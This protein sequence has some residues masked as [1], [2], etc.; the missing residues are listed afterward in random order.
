MFPG[1]SKKNA[2]DAFDYQGERSA[3]AIV[4]A[5]LRE[6]DQSGVPKEATEMTSVQVLED[7]CSGSNHICVIAVLPHILDSGADG[8][9]RYMELLQSVSKSFRGGAFSF[10]WFEGGSQP[11]LEEAMG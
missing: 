6:I 7:E 11:Q 3:E 1:G 10:L 9:N 4:E 5:V 2:S 8:R